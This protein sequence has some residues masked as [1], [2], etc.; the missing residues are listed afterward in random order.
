MK[1]DLNSCVVSSPSRMEGCNVV[2][3]GFHVIMLGLNGRRP[4]ATPFHCLGPFY[5]LHTLLLLL[6]LHTSTAYFYC[7]HTTAFKPLIC[8]T[9]THFLGAC[10]FFQGLLRLICDSDYCPSKLLPFI[11]CIY[12]G[13]FSSGFSLSRGGTVWALPDMISVLCGFEFGTV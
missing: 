13:A 3:D 1:S 6:I 4:R 12:T 8:S 10:Q 11:A 9:A 2:C 5:C 7:L